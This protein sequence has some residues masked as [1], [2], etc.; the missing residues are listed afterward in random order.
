VTTRADIRP[1]TVFL[2]CVLGCAVLVLRQAYWPRGSDNMLVATD[3]TP[4][5][6]LFVCSNGHLLWRIV[7][8]P[9]GVRDLSHVPYGTL[10]A[11]FVQDTP[12]YGAPRPFRNGEYLEVHVLSATHDMA[13]RGRATGPNA[14]LSR[15]WFDGPR[16]GSTTEAR[17]AQP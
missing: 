1:L 9:P 2:L 8:L 11:G 3:R 13:E 12:P 14:F 15:V 5:E 7:A 16:A 17:C 4:V 10:P 6:A